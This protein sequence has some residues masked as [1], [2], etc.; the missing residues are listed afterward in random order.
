MSIPRQLPHP[1][2][3][4]IA[5]TASQLFLQQEAMMGSDPT[6]SD[7]ERM[8]ECAERAVQMW[9]EMCTAGRKTWNETY[10]PRAYADYQLA[11]KAYQRDLQKVTP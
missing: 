8:H 5:T 10:S 9:F 3:T 1:T 7:V 11:L 6:K 2:F 4:W